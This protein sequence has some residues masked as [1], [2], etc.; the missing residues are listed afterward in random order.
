MVSDIL[1]MFYQVT[2]NESCG[3]YPNLH[4]HIGNHEK[5]TFAEAISKFVQYVRTYCENEVPT[6]LSCVN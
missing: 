5:I 4:S 2:D 3:N 6:H 1:N